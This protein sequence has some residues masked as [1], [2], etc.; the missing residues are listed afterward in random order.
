MRSTKILYP[1]DED[2]NELE[3]H[4]ETWKFVKKYL[5]DMKEGEDIT[6]GQLL[7]NIRLIEQNYL[8]AIRSSLGH[9]PYSQKEN[10][11]N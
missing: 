1:L 9:Q 8:L 7:V 11:M 2:H 5:N 4:K 10:L 3:H 6:F